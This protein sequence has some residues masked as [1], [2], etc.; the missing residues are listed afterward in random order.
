M[1]QD[2]WRSILAVEV[3]KSVAGQQTAWIVRV[4]RFKRVSVDGMDFVSSRCKLKLLVTANQWT[5]AKT[6]E[7]YE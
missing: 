7:A 4:G 2:G 5:S 3:A 1:S 6:D